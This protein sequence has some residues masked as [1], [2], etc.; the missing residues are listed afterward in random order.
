[1][2]QIDAYH[3]ELARQIAAQVVAELPRELAVQ[4]AAELRDDPS[5]QSPWLNSE[6]A[7]TYLGLEPR[8]LESMRRERRGPKFSRIGNRIVRYHVADLDAWLRE[9]AR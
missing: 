9:H 5:V 7:A 6:Q 4:V 2:T 3:A 1:M 8:G